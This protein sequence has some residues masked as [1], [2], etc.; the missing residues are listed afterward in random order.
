MERGRFKV[1]RFKKLTFKA[2]LVWFTF[3]VSSVAVA[4]TYEGGVRGIVTDSSHAVIGKAKVTLTDEGKHVSRTT[5]TDEAGLYVFTLV[6]PSTYTVQVEASGF[7]KFNRAAI[8]VGTSQTVTIDVGLE[9]GDVTQTVEVTEQVPLLNTA[10]ASNATAIATQQLNEL[11]TQSQDGRSQ[12]TVSNFSSNVVPTGGSSV[13]FTD[14]SNISYTSVAGSP[15]ATNQ[16]L[17]DGVPITD[18]ISRPVYIPSIEATADMKVQITT[19]DADMGRTGGGVWNTVIKSGTNS[20][21][22]SLFG[23]TRQPDWAANSFFSNKND[24]ARPNTPM[25]NYAGSLGGPVVIPHVYDGRNKTFWFVAEEGYRQR[26]TLSGTYDVPTALERQGNFSQSFNAN[27]SLD[28]IYNPYST[29]VVNGVVTRTPFT[30]NIIPPGMLSSIGLAIASYY[31]LPTRTSATG[32]SNFVTPLE[33]GPETRGDEFV[34]KVDQQFRSWWSANASYVHYGSLLPVVS[35]LPNLTGASSDLSE[36]FNRHV[37]ATTVNNIFTPN[38]TTVVNVRF[39]FNRFPNVILP[40]S[41]GFNPTT[42]G[43]PNYGY[44]TDFFPVEKTTNFTGLAN[45]NAS[46]VNWYSR[47][48]LTGVTKNLGRHTLKAGFDYRALY[49]A[50]VDLSDAAGTYNYTG[51]FTQ[52]N[53]LAAAG[54]TGSAIAD[55]LLGLPF[56]GQIERSQHFD[57]YVHYYAGYVHDDYRVSSR[58]TINAG[59]R[60]E[61]ETGLAEQ[62]NAMVVGF[63]PTA[64]SPLATAFPG[65]AGGLEFAGVNGAPTE[66]CDL[67]HKKFAPRLGAAYSVTP[68]TVIRAGYG[69][70]W[71]PT[72]YDATAALMT[73]YTTET[74]LVS[75]NNG[76][77]TPSPTFSLSNPFPNGPQAPTGNTNGLLTGIGTPIAAYAQNLKSAMIQQYSI[78]VQRELPGHVLLDLGYVGS[79]SENLLPAPQGGGSA[80]SGGGKTNIDQLKPQYF[81]LGAA[82]LNA[83][84]PNP[85][86]GNGGVGTIGNATVTNQQLLLPYPQFTSVNVLG[87]YSS[88]TYNSA[89]VKLE[90]RMS[91]GL[92]FLTTYTWSRN[93]DG[94]YA[95]PTPGG[96]SNVGPQNVYDLGAEYSRS[97]I[98][99]PSRFTTAANYELP[100]GRGRKFLHSSKWADLA[101]GGW[102]IA[103]IAVIQ[104]GFPIEITQA[105]LNSSFGAAV[106]R[107]NA[108]GVNPATSGSLENRL[109][110][111]FNPA[112]FSIVPE[113][114]F[115]DLA[116]TIPMRGPGLANFDASIG[117]TWSIGERAKLRFIA[118]SENI[119]N[120]PYFSMPNTVATSAT[121]GQITSTAGTPR[122]IKLGGRITF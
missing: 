106:Q 32:G 16:Y 67:S 3:A 84:V 110:D 4:Q 90:K 63:N 75:S 72:R 44:Q 116:R 26:G 78:D 35:S 8:V 115:G 82:Y 99:V 114:V 103:G 66:C 20:L 77:L 57:N 119:F 122:V 28:V 22:G 42:L 7:K 25:Y 70:F 62:N 56:S 108:T 54:G 11:P 15:E 33:T 91:A 60:Y 76:G 47:N 87:T 74:P 102:S 45:D 36:V 64:A 92:V 55:L 19:Y 83:S 51:Q 61:Y 50:Y 120:T 86:Y 68:R 112:A 107:P 71:A 14:Q 17:V 117:K 59:L 41:Q 12:Y 109:S 113:Y 81:A 80:A 53:P 95:T 111:Y 100:F 13:G 65:L 1:S 101:I 89:I 18:T 29:Q 85:F 58:L 118:E 21:H 24:I 39:G 97:N 38:P 27:G 69:I 2:G 88:A 49:I 52:A 31:P 34:S 37:D 79:R 40:Q 104:T 30:N 10:D 73:G 93:M 5:T 98:D 6:D 46:V 9:L 94:S 96:A 48:L 121:F 43:F 23:V 105:N